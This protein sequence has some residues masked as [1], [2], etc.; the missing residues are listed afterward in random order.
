M[1]IVDAHHHLWDLTANHYPWLTDA[2]REMLIGD[3]APLAKNYL[4]ADFL[5]DAA[6]QNVIPAFE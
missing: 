5:A 2:R 3:P 1:R 4:V 6:G